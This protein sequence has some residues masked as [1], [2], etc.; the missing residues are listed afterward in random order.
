M[1][2]IGASLSDSAAADNHEHAGHV[3]PG[4]ASAPPEHPGSAS[5]SWSMVTLTVAGAAIWMVIRRSD[6]DPRLLAAGTAI[7]VSAAALLGPVPTTHVGAMAT[8][9][10]LLVVG[11]ALLTHAVAAPALDTRFSAKPMI[12]AAVTAAGAFAVVAIVWHLPAVH[13]A[14]MS[15]FASARW[16]LPATFP[17]GLCFWGSV[18]V[19]TLDP[20]T[21]SRLALIA[22][23]PS[24]LIGL[25]LLIANRPILPD[26]STL[27]DQRLGGALMMALDAAFLVPLLAH[28]HREAAAR[29]I[30]RPPSGP[31]SLEVN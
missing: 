29:H 7:L 4:M 22:G 27:L 24:G 15:G 5:T 19:A 30:V 20:V 3:M 12:V 28:G 25:A 6:R 14:M 11:P 1:I 31:E 9:M 16:L 8:M 13:V 17:I 10:A 26:H 18:R 21:R 23:V 2:A